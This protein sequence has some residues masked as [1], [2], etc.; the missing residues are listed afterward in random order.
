MPQFPALRM[1]AGIPGMIY[2]VLLCSEKFFEM[3][4]RFQEVPEDYGSS[5][6]FWQIP[7]CSG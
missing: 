1:T 4:K 6:G 7:Y 5:R 2:K 3:L